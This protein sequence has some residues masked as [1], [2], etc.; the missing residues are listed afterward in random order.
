MYLLSDI[1][2]D[3]HQAEGELVWQ[4]ALGD[5]ML[6]EDDLELL[7][8]RLGNELHLMRRGTPPDDYEDG[9]LDEGFHLVDDEDSIADAVLGY[10]NEEED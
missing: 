5:I 2:L 9:E 4:T 10:M 1:G 7:V 8:Q 3:M 6:D